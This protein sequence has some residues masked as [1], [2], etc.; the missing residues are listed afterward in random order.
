MSAV[1]SSSVNSLG[2]STQSINSS[3]EQISVSFS[4][5][6]LSNREN[7]VVTEND[8]EHLCHL[9]ERK[10]G[11]PPWKQIMEHS[12]PTMSYQAWQRNPQVWF[13]SL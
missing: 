2:T 7:G 1:V 11:G 5:S 13:Y 8:L 12:T 3:E 4:S 6:Q 9:I 10:D